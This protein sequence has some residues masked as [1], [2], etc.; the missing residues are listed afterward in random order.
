MTSR[1]SCCRVSQA[2]PAAPAWRIA[3]PASTCPAGSRTC[4]SLRR[5]PG[6]GVLAYVDGEAAGWCSVAPKSTYRALVRSRTIPHVQDEGA[7]SVVCFVVRPGSAGVACST[8]CWRRDRACALDGRHRA[9]ATRSTPQRARRP[10]QRYLGSVPLFEAHG[11]SRVCKT[12][13]QIGGKPRWLVRRELPLIS[14]YE[15]AGAAG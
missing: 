11:F 10:R 14:R 3:T 2:Q 15:P 12:A 1:R 5:E 4:A 8:S 9:K 6:P 7:S 13:G